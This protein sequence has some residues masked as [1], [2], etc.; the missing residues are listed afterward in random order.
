MKKKGI[1]HWLS[2]L[3]CFCAAAILLICLTEKKKNN[4]PEL[5][6]LGDSI[7]TQAQNLISVNERIQGRSGL[8]VLSGNFGGT[9]MA[10]QNVQNSMDFDRDILSMA[11]LARA[12]VSEDFSA[13]QSVRQSEPATYYF[14]E[15]VDEL[16]RV[17]F[18]QVKIL[19][20]AFGVND[21]HCG[22]PVEDAEDPMKET[23]YAGALRTAIGLIQNRYPGLRILLV[24]P[25]YSWYP[26]EGVSCEEFN[27]GGGI[28]EDYVEKE[29]EVA[30]ECDVEI[31][32]LYHDLYTHETIEDWEKY[33][34]D[35]VHPNEAG[36]EKIASAIADYLEENP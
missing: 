18:D 17:N 25:T 10:R 21:Y 26:E 32:D 12:V 15:T 9:C 13:Q 35:G 22:I 7:F 4:S 16:D 24:T 2:A 31:L 30:R 5:V 11:V 1:C 33:T 20:M 8:T 19:L 28:L 27:P 3:L 36:M 6:V 29:L 14:E 34:W 23:T